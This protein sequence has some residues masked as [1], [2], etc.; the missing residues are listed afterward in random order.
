MQTYL[1]NRG[2]V[3]LEM[4]LSDEEAKRLGLEPVGKKER[5]PTNKAKRVSHK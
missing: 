2:G 4:Q 5:T 1:V 3:D